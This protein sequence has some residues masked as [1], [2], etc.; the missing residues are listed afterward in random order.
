MQLLQQKLIDD[1]L[2][3]EDTE[4]CF[5]RRVISAEGRSRAFINGVPVTLNYLKDVGDA[6]VEIQGQNEHQRLTDRNVQRALLDDYANQ[7]DQTQRSPPAT[8]LGNTPSSA[9]TN[10]ANKWLLKTIAKNC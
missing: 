8:R 2:I 4:D 9:L 3:E 5:L 6:L 7:G 1:E 10:C